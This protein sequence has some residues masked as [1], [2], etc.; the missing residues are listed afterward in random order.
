MLLGGRQRVNK[1]WWLHE[2]YYVGREWGEINE[3]FL[4]KLDKLGAMKEAAL[5]VHLLLKKDY[6][7]SDTFMK[8]DS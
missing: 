8:E 6:E 3:Y 2:R 1:H 7:F 5:L 4:A